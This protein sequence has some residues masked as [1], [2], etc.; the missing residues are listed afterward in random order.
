MSAASA[1]LAAL[2]QAERTGRGQHLDMSSLAEALLYTD[3]WSSTD[4]Y[5]YGRERFFDI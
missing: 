4:V 2:F 3:E 5:G 1:V